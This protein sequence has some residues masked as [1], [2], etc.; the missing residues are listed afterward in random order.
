M[1]DNRP[2]Q[3]TKLPCP[4]CYRFD[5]ARSFAVLARTAPPCST[6]AGGPAAIPVNS[7]FCPQCSQATGKEKGLEQFT[8][9]GSY[10]V[11]AQGGVAV[12]RSN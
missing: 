7:G 1:Y 8:E 6:R 3:D 5:P 2:G 10:P 9:K 12:S 11:T 4:A